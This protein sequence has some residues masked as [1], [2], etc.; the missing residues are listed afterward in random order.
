VRVKLLR[1]RRLV[2][3]QMGDNEQGEVRRLSL[4]FK[5]FLRDSPA[6]TA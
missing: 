6:L 3:P 1:S 4:T 2:I 5:D